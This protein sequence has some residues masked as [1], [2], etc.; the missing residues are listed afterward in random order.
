MK[1][2][3]ITLLT[4]LSQYAIRLLIAA[5][6]LI[7]GWILV[8]NLS[9]AVAKSKKLKEHDPTL[10]TFIQS[11]LNISL[12]VLLVVVCVSIVGIPG[13]SIAALVASAGVAIGLAMQGG[14]S[15]IAG[16]IML[17]VFRPFVVGDYISSAGFEGTVTGINI[18]YTTILTV[19]NRK[20][21]L[22][23][24]SLSNSALINVTA[25]ET[26]RVDFTYAVTFD[27]DVEKAKKVL[28]LVASSESRV[29]KEP[30]SKTVITNYQ[31]GA[32]EICLRVWCKTSDYWDVYFAIQDKVQPA[33]DASG[34]K[35][36][37]PHIN[38][39]MDK[40]GQ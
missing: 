1:Q 37:H 18:F 39:H 36:A 21:F 25:E 6:I 28:K 26:R 9:K 33:F 38:V 23:N 15:N 7:V 34:I 30:A 10:L 13:S 40:D 5:V 29:L 8:G 27:S 3:L 2:F 22:P 16:G 14:L 24:G 12:K 4:W 17:L 19:D 35:L 20:V 32:Y 31:D 11:G